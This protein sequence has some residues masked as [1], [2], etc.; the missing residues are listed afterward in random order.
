M[1]ARG[2]GRTDA[3]T[4][5]T[6]GTPLSLHSAPTDVVSDP[7]PYD[8]VR[9]NGTPIRP[10][11]YRVVG[12]VDGVTLLRVADDNGGRVHGGEV[13]SVTHDEYGRLE[14]AANPDEPSLVRALALTVVGGAAVLSE[15]LVDLL[16]TVAEAVGV[17]PLAD[18]LVVAA[19]LAAAFGVTR[20]VRLRR[21]RA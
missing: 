7:R 14:T 1:K 10:G 17:G 11:V 12:V 13:V 4:P 18:V 8:H 19:A 15:V 3:R 9:S 6:R 20:L 2:Q 5:S 16:T 21:L